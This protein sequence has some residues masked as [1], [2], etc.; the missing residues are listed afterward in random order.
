MPSY[1]TKAELK[2]KTGVDTSKLAAKF[3]LAILKARI[4]K[5]DVDKSNTTAIDLSKLSNVVINYVVNKTVSNKLVTKV[6]SIDTSGF[7]L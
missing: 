4:D 3:D 5:I 1:A 2:N 6:N 7:I